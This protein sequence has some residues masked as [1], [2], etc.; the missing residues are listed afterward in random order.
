MFTIGREFEIGA[1]EIVDFARLVGRIGLRFSI[2]S[3]YV[4]NS[5]GREE[6]YRKFIVYGTKR[7]I[8]KLLESRELIHTYMQH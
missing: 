6:R 1:Q 2:S 8:S 3:E 4:A 7:K 5:N